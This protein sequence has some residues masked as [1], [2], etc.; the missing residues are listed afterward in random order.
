MKV[1]RTLASFKRIKPP[2]VT[3]GNFDGIHLGH[4]SIF[5][6]LKERARKLRCPSVVYTFDPHPLKVVGSGKSPPLIL[7]MEDKIE[8][9]ESFGIDYLVLAR[10]T[11]AFAAK[12]PAEFV[13]EVLVDGLKAAEVLVGR[14]FSFGKGRAGNVRYLK[15]LSGEYGFHVEVVPPVKRSGAVVSSSRVRAMVLGGDLR[16][17]GALLGRPLSIKG[18]VAKG[19]RIGQSIGFPTANLE[20]SSELV[21][22]N[23]VYAARVKLGRKAHNALVNI[24]VA[25]T[26]K[27]GARCV[28]VHL[29]DFKA[30]I[31][32][33]RMEVAFL[34][35]L[36]DE[37]R[38]ATKEALACQI[39]KDVGKAKK[40]FAS[41]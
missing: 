26:V 22:S 9:I 11:E 15:T 31:Y 10:F 7:D 40:V 39:K 27:R 19:S 4:Q 25:P 16:R 1:L 5:K 14:N 21:P 37:T 38:F 3:L 17:A 29:L 13:G 20:V 8:L 41:G 24:G 36:R 18:R 28:E 35:R 33:R 6:R 12:H 23:G 34:K 30:N 2:V 32:G